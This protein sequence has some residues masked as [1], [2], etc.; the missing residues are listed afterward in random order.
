MTS[1][2]P[3][4]A[5]VLFL[6]KGKA[7]GN[8]PWGLLVKEVVLYLQAVTKAVIKGN[9]CLAHSEILKI[10]LFSKPFRGTYWHYQKLSAQ[11]R[12]I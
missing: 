4:G 10:S 8:T 9:E 6:E 12:R 1:W 3:L 5:T 11:I 2:K 7:T